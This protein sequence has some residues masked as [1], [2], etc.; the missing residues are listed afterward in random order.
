MSL[1]RCEE[2]ATDATAAAVFAEVLSAAGVE[3]IRRNEGALSRYL[4]TGIRSHRTPPRGGV[5]A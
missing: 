3:R 4:P 2:I 5:P 1:V